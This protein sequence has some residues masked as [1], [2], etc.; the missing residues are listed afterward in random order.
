MVRLE[1]DLQCR[2]SHQLTAKIWKDVSVFITKGG[3]HNSR[4]ESRL[5]R[6]IFWSW[7]RATIDV[8]PPIGLIRTLKGDL[9]LDER[10]AGH[11]YFKGI[12]FSPGENN[13]SG[14]HVGYNLATESP[15]WSSGRL[16]EP[17]RRSKLI[18]E[19]WESA[20]RK[21]NEGAL[22][23]YIDFL[24]NHPTRMDVQN[25]EDLVTE[26][27]ARI[28]WAKLKEDSQKTAGFYHYENSGRKSLETITKYL[29]LQ[30]QTLSLVL[31]RILR[32]HNLILT[33]DE[34]L[35]RRLEEFEVIQIPSMRFAQEFDRALRAL[36]VATSIT[37]NVTVLYVRAGDEET[38]IAFSKNKNTLYIHEKWLYTERAHLDSD[39]PVRLS[40]QIES[41]SF[42]C[43]H[44]VHEIYHRAVG[45]INPSVEWIIYGESKP[46][47]SLYLSPQMVQQKLHDMPRHVR[48]VENEDSSIQVLW[49]DGHSHAF[50]QFYGSSVE[51]IAILHS[52]DCLS[53]VH[54]LLFHEDAIVCACPRQRIP[55]RQRSAI[56]SSTAQ[57]A[58]LPMVARY[59]KDAIFG[60]PPLHNSHLSSPII[61][62]GGVVVEFPD[63]EVLGESMKTSLSGSK[64]PKSIDLYD[65]AKSPNSVDIEIGVGQDE[66]TT[67][68]IS[69]LEDRKSLATVV[70]M[71]SILAAQYLESCKTPESNSD[72][73]DSCVT[74]LLEERSRNV[75]EDT[76]V[77][78]P[79][80]PSAE[81]KYEIMRR[82]TKRTQN[83]LDFGTDQSGQFKKLKGPLGTEDSI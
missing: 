63:D 82:I 35:Q 23:L 19:I 27:V 3:K 43:E 71:D 50:S 67:P 80:Y 75:R 5:T 29:K 39:C 69:I 9:I 74:P 21:G 78:G 61:A 64:L 83:S 12:E 20:I 15:G 30:P 28:I 38:D 22:L 17:E 11:L 81:A 49:D 25:A 4:D 66:Q 18:A 41:D 36:L 37:R 62:T 1:R 45:L 72:P 59:K 42:F 51:Y 6:D 26:I 58:Y 31:W 46:N 56:F 24:R 55:Q 47:K 76:K 8:N 13:G 2:I 40:P 48:V 68:H 77:V 7:M 53:E 73:A 70:S 44:I 52:V 34:E 60:F 65:S 54:R 79:G 14:L 16:I 10:F 32:K 57:K 33:P